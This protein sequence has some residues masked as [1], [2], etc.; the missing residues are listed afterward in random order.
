MQNYKF[1]IYASLGMILLQTIFIFMDI[2]LFELIIDFLKHMEEFELDEFI[3]PAVII[4]IF[5]QFD[6]IKNN[7][8]KAT[9][10]EKIDIYNAMLRSTHH[11]LNN[12]MNQMQIFKIEAQKQ[13]D[14]NGEVLELYDIIIKDAQTQINALENI[15]HL[16]PSSIE[17]AVQPK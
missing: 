9:Q 11:I 2:E 17:E 3:I 7:Q 1:T 15:T 10:L 16:S 8:L 6:M 13:P 14:F 5:F 4:F 12:F